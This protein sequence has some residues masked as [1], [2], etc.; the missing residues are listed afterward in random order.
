MYTF[1]WFVMER[2]AWR[3]VKNVCKEAYVHM[4]PGIFLKKEIFKSGFLKTVPRENCSRDL[5]R[6][7]DWSGGLHIR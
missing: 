5:R 3:G 1:F 4:Y 7:A 6:D 2:V